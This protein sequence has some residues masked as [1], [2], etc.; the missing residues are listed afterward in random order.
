M[1]VPGIIVIASLLLMTFNT[2]SARAEAP[3]KHY[4]VEMNCEPA[5][6]EAVTTT[7]L[8][9]LALRE[10]KSTVTVFIDVGAIPL[11]SQA[12]KSQPDELREKT[13]KLFEKLRAS[14][15]VVIVCPHCAEQQ[16]LPVRSLRPGLR[17]TD[18]E[19]L[20]DQRKRADNVYE[21][22]PADSKRQGDKIAPDDRTA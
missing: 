15:V 22:R 21:Y 7:L 18:K 11:A 5:D 12:N 20:A 9:A 14:G 19:E 2:L 13:D 3:K 17:F 10:D 1:R 4:L 16:G 8:T 6:S